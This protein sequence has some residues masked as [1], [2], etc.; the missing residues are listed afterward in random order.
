MYVIFLPSPYVSED[1]LKQEYKS[2][3]VNTSHTVQTLLLQY[4]RNSVQITV[5]FLNFVLH[6]NVVSVSCSFGF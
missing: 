2:T 6:F 4:I 3:E 5:V 1:F